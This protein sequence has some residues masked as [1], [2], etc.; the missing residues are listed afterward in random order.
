MSPDIYFGAT[1]THTVE[2]WIRPSAVDD[3]I[4]SELGQSTINAGYHF[5]GAQIL[6]TEPFNQI[7]CSLWNGTA[8]TRVVNGAGSYLNTWKQVVRVYNGSVLTSYLDGVI[9]GTI[10]IAFDSPHDDGFTDWYLAFGAIDTTTYPSSVA[11]YFAGRYGIIRYYRRALTG[12][13]VLQN[14]NSTVNI[15]NT[16][17][18]TTTTIAP[19]LTPTQ[20]VTP[21]PTNTQ[22]QTPTPTVTPNG[23]VN[24]NLLL[25]LD[26]SL[27]ESYPGSGTTWYD[28][29]DTQQNMTLVNS[30][31]FVSGAISYFDFSGTLQYAQGS[32]VTVPTTVYTKSVWFWVDV[33]TDNNIVSGYD[34]T[35]GHF[36]YMSGTNKI[37]VGHHNQP[38]AF[39]T[40][41]STGTIS[42]NTWYNVTVTFNT[43]NGFKIYINGQFDSSH[44]MTLAHL[45]SGTTNLASYANTGGNYLNGRISKVYTWGDVLSDQEVL[46]MYN[47]DAPYF[48]YVTPTPTNSSTPTPTPTITRTST[49]TPTPTSTLTSTPSPT[50]TQTPTQT[51]TNSSTPTQTP[52]ITTTPSITPSPVSSS[53]FTATFTNGVSP[54]ASIENSWTTFRS[55][56]TGTYTTMNL[57][58][59]LGNSITVTDPLVQNIADALRTATTGTNTT[60]T[61]GAYT[62]RVVHGCVAGTPDANSIFLTTGGTCD[63]SGTFTVRPMIKNANWG[64]LSGSSC[65]QPTQTITLS[66]S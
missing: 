61:I 20:T 34:G 63:C 15:Y 66:F 13:E 31:T 42:L 59:N 62:W 38:V 44:N 22:T 51:P 25:R 57:S 49:T 29:A 33:Y 50:S 11:G 4:W 32:G 52:T 48:G 46:D 12:S 18:T 1:E 10:S 24:D 3:C 28:L 56:L 8:V 2:V 5:A 6:P 27:S 41:Q 26:A 7:I 39:N 19:S 16:T 14:Y 54:S 30:P 45:G 40:Y 43:T 55:Q 36:L 58:N 47:V 65:N 64:G 53:T 60:I 37:N 23:L 17:T 9:G 35:G 21:T